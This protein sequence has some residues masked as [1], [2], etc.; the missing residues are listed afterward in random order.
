MNKLLLL[1]ALATGACVANAASSDYFKVFYEGKEIANGDNLICTTG[2]FSNP[3]LWRQYQCF[4][5]IVSQKDENQTISADVLY[6][7]K[8]TQQ[9]VTANPDLW[10]TIALCYSQTYESYDERTGEWRTVFNGNCFPSLP[11]TLT[12][13]PE[14]MPNTKEESSFEYELELTM[15]SLEVVSTY[16]LQIYIGTPS[17][18]V[19][20]SLYSVFVTFQNEGAG[21][22]SITSVSTPEY[23]N[24]QGMRVENPANGIYIVKRGD[25]ISKEYIHK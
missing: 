15:P 1:A 16:E 18:K 8:P 7:G 17:N 24:I 20:D 19:E 4:L 23:Y 13:Y 10:G 5:E 2:E 12:L 11:N 14:I 3:D 21:V 6:T 9:E 22:D 25:K